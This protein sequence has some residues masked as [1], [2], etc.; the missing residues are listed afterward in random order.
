MKLKLLFPA[1]LFLSLAGCS[2]EPK[3][4][5]TL[6]NDP[7]EELY[8]QLFYDVQ[9]L[10]IFS[11]SKT[12]VDCVPLGDL[13]S[14]NL[15][16]TT[17]KNKSPEVILDFVKKNFLI[18]PHEDSRVDSLS[19]SEDISAL[20]KTLKH[21]ADK[22]QNGTLLAL[23]Y[24]YVIAGESVREMHYWDSYFAMLGLLA[25]GDIEAVQNSVDNFSWMIN[26]YGFVPA[27]NR[28]Y[29]LSRSQPPVFA[30]MLSVLVQSKG[31]STYKKYLPALEKEYAFWMRGSEQ[32]KANVVGTFQ[33]VVK[34]PGGEI[35]NR[36]WDDQTTPRAENYYEDL[37]AA[38][39]ASLVLKTYSEKEL[40]RNI[41][42]A[43]ES[44]WGC[45]SRWIDI[46]GEN[47]YAPAT[48][49]T[50]DFIPVDLN[51]LLYYEELVL[52]HTYSLTGNISKTNEFNFRAEERMNAINNYC[53][54]AA[55]NYYFDF[56][57]KEQRHSLVYSLA[58]T[59]PLFF[60]L[61][62]PAQAKE[63][64][65]RIK[66]V[67]LRPGGLVTTPYKTGQQWDSPYGYA[68][69]QW[70]AIKGLRNYNFNAT[71]DTI[72]NRWLKLAYGTYKTTGH[73]PEKYIV[74][75]FATESNRKEK[76]NSSAWTIGVFQKLNN[77]QNR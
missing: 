2:D 1:F 33:R 67:F 58:G 9:S 28:S 60:Q 59:F 45:S 37:K 18:P 14:I 13:D 61:A 73:F 36:Y 3:L 4:P 12:F 46:A 8:G 51:C 76:L 41:R 77:E 62:S 57:C 23:P 50:T 35:L 43:A 16:Y 71:A 21:P 6:R 32:L 42:A 39:E 55:K 25:D 54:S 65:D 66:G 52:A 44:G 7:P 75:E 49:H 70:M 29:Y 69:L 26:H 64:E 40:Y 11:D 27:G 74:E 48:I 17:L 22:K 5:K 10:R 34:L 72:K 56:N 53:W 38:A 68:P 20:W 30:L 24:P 63:V 31:D 19:A 15:E 47:M